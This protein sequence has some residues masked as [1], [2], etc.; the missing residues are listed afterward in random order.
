M[1]K[2]ISTNNLSKW[3]IGINV[4]HANYSKKRKY[5]NIVCNEYFWEAWPVG[6]LNICVF[7][8]ISEIGVLILYFKKIN[9]EYLKDCKTL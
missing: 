3:H 2:K 7:G 1:Y 8:P 4:T 5:E 6:I 9:F